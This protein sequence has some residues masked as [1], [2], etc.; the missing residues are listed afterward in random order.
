MSDLK[1]PKMLRPCSLPRHGSGSA[2][3]T[4]V[5]H[6]P[7]TPARRPAPPASRQPLPDNP[8]PQV[9]SPGH[10]PAQQ[11]TPH[12][13]VHGPENSVIP[14]TSS[15]AV[16]SCEADSF[17]IPAISQPRIIGFSSFSLP[18]SPFPILVF[19]STGLMLIAF[20]STNTSPSLIPGT[21]NSTSSS[22]STPP[23]SFRIIAFIFNFCVS[24]TKLMPLTRSQSIRLFFS[25]PNRVSPSLPNRTSLHP[26][27][28]H[29]LYRKRTI[30]RP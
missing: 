10:P 13:H 22:C 26:P 7:K 1:F 17:T 14:N 20:T 24:A 8:L 5:C 19:T 29:S 25:L 4:A 28:A 30:A 9:S 3:P 12:K 2:A 11:H 23:N 6:D 15:P 18:A 16:N 27:T 21:G